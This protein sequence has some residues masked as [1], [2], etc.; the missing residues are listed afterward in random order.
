MTRHQPPTPAAPRLEDSAAPTAPL[1][2]PAP[3]T[4]RRFTGSSIPSAARPAATATNPPPTGPRPAPS[5]DSGPEEAPISTFAAL[6]LRNYRLYFSGQIVSNSG[7]WMQRIAQD[8]LVL[9]I[10]NSPLAVGITT[11]LQFL[12]MLLFG[13]FGGLL[14][15]RYP[16]R[17][18]LLLT[19]S[20][21]GLLALALAVLTL[22]GQIQVWHIYAVAFGLGLVTVVD[23]PTRQVFVNE[24]VPARLVRNAVSL[25]SGTFQIARMVGPAVAGVLISAVGSGW[26][27][28]INAASFLATIGA[29]LA[30]DA[31]QLQRIPRAARE[32]GQLREGLRYVRARPHIMWLIVLVFF[33][34]TFGYN[35]AIILSAYAKDV[36]HSNADVYGL[37][38]TAM[39]VGS[40]IGALLAA[41]R[42]T[43]RLSF[44]FA[45]AGGFSVMLVVL[46]AVPWL[47]PFTALL[48]LAGLLSIT[49]NTTANASIQLSTDAA[50]RGRVMSLYML[51]FMGGT[52]VGGPLVGAITDAWG[53]P[54]AIIICGVVC[55]IA[56]AACAALAARQ[57]GITL[58]VNLHRGVDRH[59]LLVHRQG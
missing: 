1:R 56:T 24:M 47:I 40:V 44:L 3:P 4:A 59:L 39:A 38:N 6:R 43:V 30:M 19:Q 12:P 31:A 54:V 41:R 8:W 50:V 29:L 11:A 28:A 45:A 35:F 7:T 53:A 20:V 55:V 23:N 10:T 51:V 2:S 33:I 36:F 13:L 9:E 48:V 57:A 5:P 16:K 25:N 15:D 58:R 26:A 46:G 52:P 22:S 27:F 42:V 37:L 21:M 14:A 49:F 17:R 34:G 18:L 32:K